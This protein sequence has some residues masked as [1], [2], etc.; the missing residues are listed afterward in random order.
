MATATAVQTGARAFR[1]VAEISARRSSRGNITPLFSPFRVPVI[2]HAGSCISGIPLPTGASM[3]GRIGACGYRQNFL[4]SKRFSISAQT[5]S[6]MAAPAEAKGTAT[7]VDERVA[8]LRAVMETVDCGQ[9][10]KGVHAYIIP[11]EDAHQ[12]EYSP[13]CFARREFISRFTGSAGIAAVTATEACLWTDGRYFLQAAAELPA[14]WTLM[15]S[16]QPGVP[17]L[18]DWL[19]KTLP[20]GSR[21][22]VD[23]ALHSAG[24]L[25]EMREVL[26]RAGSEVVPIPGVNLVDRVWGDAR[27]AVPMT[28]VRIHPEKYAGR[29]VADKLAD[30]RKDMREAE[31]GALIVALLDEVAWLFNLRGGDVPHVPVSL[32]Y[33]IV[34]LEA[35]TLFIDERK[36]GD[37]V[38]QHLQA[39]GVTLQPYDGMLP[40]VY[41]LGLAGTKLWMDPAK[42]NAAIF[43][44]AVA[45]DDMR[46]AQASVQ[47]KKG[48][49]PG[50]KGKGKKGGEGATAKG[51]GAAKAD[52][53]EEEAASS[54]NSAKSSAEPMGVHAYPSPVMIYKAMKNE[55]ELEGMRACHIRD[56]AALAEFW[57]WL[58]EEI[59]AGKTPSEYLVGEK[60]KSFREAAGG[61]LD[62][63]FDTIAG[64][65][66]NGAVIHYRAQKDT[67][68]NVNADDLFLLDS[69]GQYEDGTTDI[70]RTVHFGTP[71][72]RQKECFTRVL[73][74]HIALDQQVFPEG[75]PGFALD[76]LARKELWK[77][78]LDYRHG[79]GHGVGAALGVHEGPQSVSPRF[80]N[81]TGL[82]AGMIVSNE[83]GYY[84]DGQFGIRIEVG[85]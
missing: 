5:V 8:A 70:T 6:S 84:E 55:A 34:E 67:C 14:G 31:A 79:T 47:K 15:R 73:Q 18:Q 66:A 61:F 83:P 21:V 17:D 85:P 65:G 63:S 13:G 33:A 44:A 50:G 16:G 11:S 56:G 9:G 43:G 46:I 30:V 4:V 7:A 51:F 45:G 62:T 48:G 27:P 52:G 20:P 81:M 75:T 26:G 35:V 19:A 54:V 10:V 74:G 60:L 68:R 49:A 3:H 57:C 42:V 12:S 24:A 53:K 22:G 69:G 38:K 78:G 72:E 58:E 2:R 23:P 29:S 80:G 25:K 37:P 64:S 76:I 77:F 1:Q 32:A 36:L 40:A 41:N 71:T 39:N 59:A 28:P 82:K